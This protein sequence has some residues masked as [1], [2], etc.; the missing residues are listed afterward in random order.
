MLGLATDENAD[1]RGIGIVG[2]SVGGEV[3]EA[4]PVEDVMASA[5]GVL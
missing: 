3:F 1:S 5:I 2:R 4:Q